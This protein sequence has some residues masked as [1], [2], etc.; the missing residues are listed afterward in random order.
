MKK[1]MFKECVK[2]VNYEHDA[3]FTITSWGTTGDC[4]VRL[5]DAREI[6]PEKAVEKVLQSL[7]N[8]GVA[9]ELLFEAAKRVGMVAGVNTECRVRVRRAKK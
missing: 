8:S 6:T 2:F 7:F 5:T 3:E 4:K 1:P 9:T